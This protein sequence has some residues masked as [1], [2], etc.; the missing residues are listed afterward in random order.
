MIKIARIYHWEM[1]HRLPFHQGAC[2]NIH[3]HS[4]SMWIEIFGKPDENGVILDFYE[5]DKIVLPVVGQ[6]DHSF[7]CDGNDTVMSA[8]LQQNEF[9]HT[10]IP[11]PTTCENLSGYI[12]D[13]FYPEL[14]KFKNIIKFNIRLYETGDAFAEVEK[15]LSSTRQNNSGLLL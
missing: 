14:Q 15:V 2:K 8:F 4:Y 13:I 3:G 9:K 7:I 6:L 1:S 12:A 10:I 5:L 11:Y